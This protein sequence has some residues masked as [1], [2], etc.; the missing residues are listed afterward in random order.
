MASLLSKSRRRIATT[1]AV[2]AL[3]LV[4][5]ATSAAARPLEN[6]GPYYYECV[7]TSGWIYMLQP[8]DLLSSCKGSFLKTYIAGRLVSTIPLT[9]YGTPANPDAV[10]LDCLIAIV[11]VGASVLTLD[12]GWAWVALGAL[13]YGLKSCKA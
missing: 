4:A 10:K 11:G 8:G 7:T 13:V 6:S 5:P 3:A 1:A 12:G 9:G 2:L